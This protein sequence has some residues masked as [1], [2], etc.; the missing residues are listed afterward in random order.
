MN[1]ISAKKYLQPGQVLQIPTQGYDEYV[2]SLINTNNTTKIYHTVRSGDTLSEIASKYR[3]SIKKIK[4]WNGIREN[5][6]VIYVGKKLIIFISA[7]DYQRINSNTPKTVNYKVKYGD[8]LSKIS[9][10]FGVRVSDIRKWNSLKSDLIKVG[11]NLII[12]TK[13]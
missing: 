5:D 6:N 3:T 8:S 7:N 11:Q 12:K 13:N 1:K 9:Y 10:K 4:K 2:K